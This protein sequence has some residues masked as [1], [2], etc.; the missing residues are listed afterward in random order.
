MG[1]DWE[2]SADIIFSD[3]NNGYD[4]YEA[5]RSVVGTAPD[6]RPIYDT[7]ADADYITRNT[8]EGEGTVVTLTAGKLFD[9]DFGVIDLNLGYTHQDIEELR[10]YNRFVTFETLA[11][12]PSTDLN[13]PGTATSRYEVEH[14][15]TAQLTWENQIFGDNKTM[16]G[17][18]Y[19][20]RSGTNY[21]YVF[22]SQGIPTFGGNFLADFG[23]E[24]DNIGNQLF[25]VPTGVS[26]PIITGD[27]Q[28]LSDLDTFIDRTPCLSRN[29]GQTVARNSCRTGWI[30][31]INMRL[32]QEIT[33]ANDFSFDLTLDIEN[34]GNLINDNW[35][36]V[37]NY[38]APSNVAP[39]GV[40]LSGDGS[41]YVLSPLAGYEAGNPAS[42]VPLPEIAQLPSVYRIQLGIAFRF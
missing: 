38:S 22:G 19:Q 6:G 31:T 24:G 29:R 1:D 15:Y 25:Y 37:E 32:M 40:A 4:I 27:A 17:L 7:P 13:N 23:S 9:T 34:L 33:L 26:D 35:G 2:L 16:V 41:Q 12:D 3:V 21:S 18:V 28:F 42:L 39:A 11:F 10:S 8:S 30:N 5:R 36:R 20:G 14:R